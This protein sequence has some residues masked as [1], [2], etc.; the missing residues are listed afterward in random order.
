MGWTFFSDSYISRVDPRLGGGEIKK[1]IVFFLNTWK[2]TPA[3]T[4]YFLPHFCTLNEKIRKGKTKITKSIHHIRCFSASLLRGGIDSFSFVS[5]LS[6]HL[7]ATWFS[8]C[9]NTRPFSAGGFLLLH[10]LFLPPFYYIFGVLFAQ[11]G[12]VLSHPIA[13]PLVRELLSFWLCPFTIIIIARA[14]YQWLMF[15]SSASPHMDGWMGKVQCV[16]VRAPSVTSR[17]SEA[18]AWAQLL[19][20]HRALKPSCVCVCVS[21]W[22][23]I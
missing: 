6:A 17:E 4:L 5:P 18:R 2:L 13:E 22:H 21:I 1:R 9:N 20:V 15:K 19:C 10:I 11:R 7:Y 16:C 23:G 12:P 3:C 14:Q 8:L